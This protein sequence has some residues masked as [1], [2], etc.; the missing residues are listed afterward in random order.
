MKQRNRIWR[1]IITMAIATLVLAALSISGV[2]AQDEPA[3]PTADDITAIKIGID[4]VRV[5]YWGL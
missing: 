1:N 3:A 4:T 2:M 5:Q